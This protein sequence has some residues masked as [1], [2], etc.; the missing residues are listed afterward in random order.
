MTALTAS[1]DRVRTYATL[2]FVRGA[3]VSLAITLC[4][5][6]IGVLHYIP[7]ATSFLGSL[8]FDFAKLRPI[9]T[10]FASAW[11]FLGGV[12]VVHHYLAE[13]GGP[14]TQ[15][16]RRRLQIQVLLWALAGGL[17]LS[18][19]AL[20]IGSGREYMG[21]HPA[22]SIP[23]LLGWL[24]FA[25]NFFRVTY[26]GFWSQPV[27]ITMWGIGI[28]FFT[29]TFIE[30]HAWLLPGVFSDPVV[31][32]RVQWK[33]CGTLV[34]SFN[35]FVYG[36]L[37][38]LGERLSGDEKYAQSTLAYSL[39]GVGLLNSFTNFAHHTYHLPQ[40]EVI[41]WI[42]FVVSMAEIII[43]ARVMLDLVGLLRQRN[44]SPNDAT[45][46]F[47]VSAKWWTFAMLVTSIGIAVPPL[48]AL[49]HGTHVVTA[50]AM[51][52]EIGIDSMVLFAA[53]TW[54][55]ADR[56]SANAVYERLHSKGV[57]RSL[58]GLN[59]GLVLLVT[60]LFVSGTLTGLTRY[61]G[62]EAPEWLVVAG[63]AG[64][65]AGGVLTALFVAR[66][67]ATWIPLAFSP[68]TPGES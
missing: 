67:L 49:I 21:F 20:G 65:V 14:A 41:K 39:L 48:N 55:L 12:A 4:A 1:K 62:Q 58:V 23:I 59:C 44:Q 11:I 9:H 28:L 47:V 8:G 37:Y 45:T 61:Q 46:G 16:D 43:L 27:Y 25:W 15:G 51:G 64:F 54:L 24:C 31:D 5:G 53:V 57:R 68:T 50:H 3:L 29:F 35:L 6:A 30:Q 66:L 26:K 18:T 19:L 32:L 42:A 10:T 52:T 60:W 38:Y 33:A 2:T 13:K 7:W 34:G 17:A 22:I 36:S 40:N 63:P 56:T